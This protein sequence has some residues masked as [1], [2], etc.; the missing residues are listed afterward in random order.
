MDGHRLGN[1]ALGACDRKRHASIKSEEPALVVTV[2][3]KD[4]GVQV[5]TVRRKDVKTKL[6]D[7]SKVE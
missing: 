3:R 4:V 6:G 1:Q 7:T 5:V 2:R